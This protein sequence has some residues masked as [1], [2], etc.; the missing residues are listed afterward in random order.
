MPVA[1][2]DDADS[3]LDVLD[4]LVLDAFT[5]GREPYARMR[6]L[7]N[8][9]TRAALVPAGAEVI[10]E[11]VHAHTL[12]WLA[13]GDGWTLRAVHRRRQ[14]RATITVTA[15][16]AE[17]ARSVM[18]LATTDATD[19]PSPD[20]SVGIGFWYLSAHGPRRI[21][22][23]IEAP[24]WRDIR[25]NYSTQVSQ[26]LEPLM[27]LTDGGRSGR[28]ILLHGPPGT[29]KTTLLRAIAQQWKSWCRVDCVL[30]PERLFGD[31]AYLMDVA[32]GD[33]YPDSTG[34][35]LLLLEDCDEFIRGEAKAHAGQHLSRLLNL[36]DGLLGQGRQAL[37]AITTNENVAALH[38]AVIRPGRCLAQVEVGRLSRDEAVR[39]LR[40]TGSAADAAA[41]VSADGATLAELYALV[42][43]G[44][45]VVVTGSRP[46]VGGYL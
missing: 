20:G 1:A 37:V 9:R 12:G 32:L 44:A 23:H 30:D 2:V 46:A 29:G 21:P 22:R 3:P 5:S 14:R 8:V 24:T 27:N 17:L 26:A 13:V 33:D 19:P 6:N 35:R 45:P 41:A 40:A 39:W 4:L 18:N 38:P 42:S 31:P 36:T 11:V 43:D 10:R 28:L 16:S 15:V 7:E 34:W 25:H